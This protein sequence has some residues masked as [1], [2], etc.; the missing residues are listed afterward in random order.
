LFVCYAG[1]AQAR[2]TSPLAG[3]PPEAVPASLPFHPLLEEDYYW[4][5]SDVM[6]EEQRLRRIARIYGLQSNLLS[7]QA[8]GD[9]E[10][11]A[12][13]LGRAMDE[14][15]LLAT[16]PGIMDEARFRELYRSLVTEHESMY[17]HADTLYVPFGEIYAFQA[18]MFDALNNVDEPL[19]ETVGRINIQPL[20]TAVPM[21]M[22]RLV[23]STITYLVR[24]P[25]RHVNHWLS[26]AET[27]LPMIEQI[28]AEEGVP[29]ELKYLAMI[30]SGLNPRARSWARAV[31]MWQFMAATGRAY[32]LQVNNWIDERMDP[33]KATRA[34]ARH[35]LD[36]YKRQGDWHLV[37]ANYNCS[38]RCINRAK[39]S[40][41][42]T[43]VSDP[44]FWDIYRYLPRE[45]RNYVPMFIAT[46]LVTSNPEAF[47]LKRVEA[48]P[49][50]EY[51]YVPV[52]G[53]LSLDDIATMAGTD[54]ATIKALNPELR[55]NSLPPTKGSY[56]LRIPLG[57]YSRFVDAYANLPDSQ[58]RP[59]AE[60][61]V[62][63]GDNLGQIARQYG[64]SVSALKQHN[65]L[66]SNTIGIGQR[67][68][69]PVPVYDNATPLVTL[70]D[71]ESMTV[72]YRGLVRRPIAAARPPEPVPT[73][74]KPTPVVTA[75]APV[76]NSASSS[77]EPSGET[78]V[79]Y[80]VR[81]GDTLGKI[82]SRYG[83]SVRDL[84]GW[85]SLRGTQISIGQRLSIYAENPE[86]EASSDEPERV[87]YRVRRGDNLG[88]ISRQYGVSVQDLQ[89]W[90]N[91]R[92]TQIRVGQRLTIYPKGSGQQAS[93]Q[94]ASNQSSESQVTTYRVRSG[95]TLIG[96]AKQHG[97]TVNRLKEWNDL[98][99]SRIRAGQRLKIYN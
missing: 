31:G 10:Q 56:Y 7:A 58:K 76:N 45:T 34:A 12:L 47:D 51:H 25:D 63:R 65:G 92:G 4:S 18:E 19:L 32:G 54:V 29:D 89:G 33:E 78:R 39:R 8:S 90:N 86:A 21:T 68:V 42:A 22:N 5:P 40:A 9:T 83:V 53:M 74:D 49:R 44:D 14:L 82:A 35:L 97:V 15:A 41:R 81:R 2:Q 23:E 17:G 87:T 60:Y 64:V 80:T 1:V 36:L 61:V 16:Q 70:A 93:G 11:A 75:S 48:G 69:V 6:T 94:Q 30:E 62:R 79:T 72:Q 13:L 95:D 27:Y 20:G 24:E 71:T 46:A 67:L 77:S 28:F 50:Y 85:N 43:G 99:S 37:L 52:Q 59:V 66:K 73:P 98:S 57:S 84:Q 88:K 96:I 26:R 91:L 55:R 38:P 3:R